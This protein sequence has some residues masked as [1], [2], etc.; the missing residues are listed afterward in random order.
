M[1]KLFSCFISALVAVSGCY[2]QRSTGMVQ[3]QAFEVV[4]S[5]VTKMSPGIELPI[6]EIKGRAVRSFQRNF[7]NAIGVKWYR[8]SIGYCASMA[9]ADETRSFAYYDQDGTFEYSIR[10]YKE[11]KLPRE[12]RHLV[13]SRFYD[14]SIYQVSEVTRNRKIAYI[15]KLEDKTHWKTIKVIGDAI[16]TIDELSKSN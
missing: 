16:E 7:K 6:N 3:S 10:Y 11:D 12:V 2:S 14:Y 13:K 5:Q 1:K 15:V 9:N 4:S 8:C